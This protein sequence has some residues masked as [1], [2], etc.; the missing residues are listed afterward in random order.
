[1]RVWVDTEFNEHGSELISMG[2]AA[3]NGADWYEVLGCDNPGQWV[4]EH[5]MPCLLKDRV[6]RGRFAVS[7]SNYLA[8]FDCIHLISDWPADIS[9]FCESLITGPGMRIDTPPITME[10]DRDLPATADISA[11]PHNAL[12]DAQA[13]RNA[14]LASK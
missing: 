8:Q 12:S 4:A 7:L 13:L 10:I 14:A 9:H 6:S 3:E 5:V 1:M 2:L 11:I